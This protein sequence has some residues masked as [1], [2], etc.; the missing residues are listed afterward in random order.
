MIK[1]RSKT[2]GHSSVRIYWHREL[3]PI[4]AE[5]L[6]EHVAEAASERVP[7]MLVERDELW[8]RCYKELMDKARKRLEQEVARLGGNCAHVLDEFVESRHDGATGEGWLHGR[9]TYMLY[10]SPQ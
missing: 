9:F 3:P 8:D 2:D 10:R 7:H 1:H 6:G 4:D 5:P